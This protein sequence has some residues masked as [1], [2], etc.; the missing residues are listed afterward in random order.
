MKYIEQKT[1]KGATEIIVCNSIALFPQAKF[2][3][4]LMHNLAIAAAVP[5]GEDS[6]GKQKMRQMTEMEVVYRATKIS[7]IAFADFSARGWIL[8]LPMPKK[9]P[10]L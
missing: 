2:A 10:D 3:Q 5:D 8:D 9:A 4:D 6:S 1:Y 7:Q